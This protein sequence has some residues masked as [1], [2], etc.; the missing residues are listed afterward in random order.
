MR[1]QT[2]AKL[3]PLQWISFFHAIRFI[4]YI[5]IMRHFKSLAKLP[6]QSMKQKHAKTADLKKLK[7]INWCLKSIQKHWKPEPS[8]LVICLTGSH[9]LNY[10]KQEFDIHIGIAKDPDLH[11]HAWLEAYGYAIWGENDNRS[12]TPITLL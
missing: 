5:Q 9:L 11:A 1:I 6:P 7:T 4:V 10:Y 8:C 2:F 3:T 12:F